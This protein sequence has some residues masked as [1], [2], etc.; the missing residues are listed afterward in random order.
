MAYHGSSP[1]AALLGSPVARRRPRQ[2]IH[3]GLIVLA[4]AATAALAWTLF[5]QDTQELLPHP[6]Q[7]SYVRSPVLI[8]YS[9]YE[10]DSIQVCHAT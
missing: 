4:L 1:A 9:Y 7:P 2:G 6:G 3:A 10:K 8:S 5:G